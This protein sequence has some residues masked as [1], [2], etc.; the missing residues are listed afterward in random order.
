MKPITLA[1]LATLALAACTH[2]KAPA[3]A[4]ATAPPP[5][6]KTV[7]DT[8]FK[9][10]QKAKDVQKTVDKQKQDLDKQMQDQGG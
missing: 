5:P 9:A 3:D 6:R 10:L 7:F 4:E 1:Y 8:Q 2:G